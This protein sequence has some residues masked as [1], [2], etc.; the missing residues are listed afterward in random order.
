MRLC[1]AY[2]FV[3]DKLLISSNREEHKREERELVAFLR[4]HARAVLRD[5]RFNKTRKIAMLLLRVN[6]SLYRR[7]VLWQKKHQKLA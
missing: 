6:T 7:C 4:R 2:F 1:W 3:L 5:P